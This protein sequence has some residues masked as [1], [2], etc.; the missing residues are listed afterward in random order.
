MPPRPPFHAF[1]KTSPPSS[2]G[3]KGSIQGGTLAMT[4]PLTWD[5]LTPSRQALWIE[6]NPKKALSLLPL[7]PLHASTSHI[8]PPLLNALV[9]LCATAYLDAQELQH[10]TRL[11]HQYKRWE[12]AALGYLC[13]RQYLKAKEALQNLP[14]CSQ[15]SWADIVYRAASNQLDV[16]PSFLHLRNR[17]EGDL[18]LMYRFQAIDCM[19]QLMAYLGSFAQLNPEVYKLVG[20]TF[21]Y[22]GLLTQAYNLFQRSVQMNPMDTE[23]YYHLGQLYIET[24]QTKHARLMF[25]Q[26]L[27]MN[28]DYTPASDL[29]QTL[30]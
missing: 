19:E 23:N 18:F 15:I 16:W 22:S 24:R 28:P 13:Q 21:M 12:Q 9:D 29:L 2:K 4:V 20:R 5:S 14:K 30:A 25:Q 6:K 11:L 26:V 1:L 8:D 10:A 17:L 3:M 27:A 7:N